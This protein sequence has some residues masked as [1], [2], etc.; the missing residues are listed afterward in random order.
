MIYSDFS[1]H[2]AVGLKIVSNPLTGES[3][4]K[5]FVTKVKI[6]NKDQTVASEV[7]I[8]SDEELPISLCNNT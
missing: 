1:V 8:Y 4:T 7:H 5:F 6:L 2:N 3:G